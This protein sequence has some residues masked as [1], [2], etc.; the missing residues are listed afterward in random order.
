MLIG[1][2]LTDDYD[3]FVT[4]LDPSQTGANQMVYTTYIRG[5]DEDKAFGMGVDI[6]G[7]ACLVGL[8]WSDDFPTT[9]NA[10]QRNLDGSGDGVVVQLDA[11]GAVHYASYL[12][13]TG[14]EELLQVA[15][16]DNGLIYAVGITDSSDF[17]MTGNA[18]QGSISRP[19]WVELS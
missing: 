3:I 19:Q 8:T 11:T 2:V 6:A 5:A 13:G 4:K 12:G 1:K 16:G 7:N 10:F 17:P 14:F 15:V 9:P 18:Y